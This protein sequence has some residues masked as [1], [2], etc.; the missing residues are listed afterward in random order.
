MSSSF[1][2]VGVESRDFSQAEKER[3]A[4]KADQI[5]KMTTVFTQN[6]NLRPFWV[7]IVVILWICSALQAV[8]SFSVEEKSHDSTPNSPKLENM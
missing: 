6:D 4:C 3:K 1:W 2:L 8:L 7:K 5:H